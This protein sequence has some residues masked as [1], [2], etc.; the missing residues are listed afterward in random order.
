MSVLSIFRVPIGCTGNTDDW[1]FPNSY[2]GKQDISENDVRPFVS[3]S[4]LPNLT[5][6]LFSENNYLKSDSVTQEEIEILLEKIVALNYLVQM[7][8][9]VIIP[10]I[11][12]SVSLIVVYLCFIRTKRH[13]PTELTKIH[14]GIADR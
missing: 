8:F 14:P 9:Y 4:I 6:E 11:V 2:S 5:S 13:F 3:F 1:E 12:L 7:F 10:I